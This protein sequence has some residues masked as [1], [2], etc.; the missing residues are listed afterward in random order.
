MSTELIIGSV[1]GIVGIAVSIYY[2]R[3][4]RKDGPSDTHDEPEVQLTWGYLT[5]GPGH[6]I[7]DEEMLILTLINNQDQP[8]TWESAGLEL[9][10]GTGRRAFF[11]KTSPGGELPKPVEARSS[12]RTWMSMLEA[13]RAGIDLEKPL[14]GFATTGTGQTL[15]SEPRTLVT[16]G[17]EPDSN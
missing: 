13:M 10:D 14:V 8:I 16:P 4:S 17:E 7:G 5:Y 11:A 12:A 1:L 3:R 9:Q 2:G 6:Q 15:R